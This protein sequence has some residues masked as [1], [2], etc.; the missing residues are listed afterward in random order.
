[1]IGNVEQNVPG[2]ASIN[3]FDPST[4]VF[5]SHLQSPNG[6]PL[7]IP[8]LWDLD[9]GAGS[10][11]NGKTNEL[12]FTAGPNA[13]TFTGNGLFGL[14]HAAGD[15]GG[16][17]AASGGLGGHGQPELL[18]QGSMESAA[19][20]GQEGASAR[21]TNAVPLG[22]VLLDSSAA[23]ASTQPAVLA[24][25]QFAGQTAPSELVDELFDAQ[26]GNT[27]WNAL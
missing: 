11:N 17:S 7:A 1:L 12:F 8:G 6:T 24:S 27:R 4:G 9:F 25:H 19:L 20:S 10:P 22:L 13:V 5:L 26:N 2:A 3:A 18:T 15:Q 16:G 23:P 21:S 14:I